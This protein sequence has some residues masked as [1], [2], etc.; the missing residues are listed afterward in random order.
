MEVW[1]RSVLGIPD[2]VSFRWLIAAYGVGPAAPFFINVPNQFGRS[3]G[4]PNRAYL[5][6]SAE[7]RF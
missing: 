4:N 2:V 6:K 5:F 3:S 1:V 7:S